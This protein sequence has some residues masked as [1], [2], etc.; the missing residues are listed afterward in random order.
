M[1]Y[2]NDSL[3]LESTNRA[4]GKLEI[5]YQQIQEKTRLHSLYQQEP[6]RALFPTNTATGVMET[7]LINMTGG[8]AGGDQHSVNIH[9]GMHAAGLITTQS[10]EKIYRSLGRESELSLRLSLDPGSWLEWI[11]QETILFNEAKL[12]RLNQIHTSRTSR[13]MSGEILIFGRTAHAERILSGLMHDHR[14]V[15]RDNHLIWVDALHLEE[16]FG[17]VL[18]HPAA[19]NG[20]RAY[21]IFIYVSDDSSHYLD[22]AREVLNEINFIHS[23]ATC[24][25]KEILVVRWL[26]ANAMQLRLA[27]GSFWRK[28]RFI[29]AGLPEQLPTLWDG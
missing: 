15:Y 17:D 6:L 21:A 23:A 14:E 2:A 20:A 26:G 16:D 29:V 4:K 1:L 13:L 5:G 3:L 18:N 28:F 9:M 27:Y 11:P 8:I 10:A 25:S 7:I 12:R 24:V 22:C 19:F